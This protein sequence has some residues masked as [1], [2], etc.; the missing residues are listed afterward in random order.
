[1]SVIPFLDIRWFL[2]H[3]G[4]DLFSTLGAGVWREFLVELSVE[5]MLVL[6][7]EVLEY[8]HVALVDESIHGD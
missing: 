2:F 1:M 7:H 6:N 3:P 5:V 4:L 8:P